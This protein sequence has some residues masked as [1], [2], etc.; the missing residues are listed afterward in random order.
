MWC[1]WLLIVVAVCVV[2][3]EYYAQCSYLGKPVN[4]KTCLCEPG[5]LPPDCSKLNLTRMVGESPEAYRQGV[6]DDNYPTFGGSAYKSDLSQCGGNVKYYWIGQTQ[7]NKAGMSCWAHNSAGSIWESTTDSPLGP[8]KFVSWMGFGTNTAGFAPTDIPWLG[9]FRFGIEAK[10]QPSA[11]SLRNPTYAFVTHAKAK[12]VKK[13]QRFALASFASPNKKQCIGHLGLDPKVNPFWKAKTNVQ[14]STVGY[15][16]LRGTTECARER[17]I[18]SI[19]DSRVL[20]SNV[21]GFTGKNEYVNTELTWYMSVDSVPHMPNSD[22]YPVNPTPIYNSYTLGLLQYQGATGKW[23]EYTGMQPGMYY[24]P[25]F[26]RWNN[27]KKKFVFREKL[28]VMAIRADMFIWE[29]GAPQYFVNQ[30]VGP[31]WY[32]D[33]W[34]WETEQGLHIYTHE[35]GA[36][37]NRKTVLPSCGGSLHLSRA[38]FDS[39]MFGNKWID[40]TGVFDNTIVSL[41]QRTIVKQRPVVFYEDGNPSVLFT[42]NLWKGKF[43][44][45]EWKS[46]QGASRCFAQAVST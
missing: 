15:R 4:K 17:E 25:L 36:C 12:Q 37:R 31:G 3:Q 20:V 23:P 46:K 38:D 34:V 24:R 44:K 30:G 10:L 22:Q 42:G 18:R 5:W 2:A 6:H 13:T 43:A 11:T 19:L 40:R 41:K 28:G 26:I 7:A 21:N 33:P 29:S 9:N 14:V 1:L 27:P 16:I 8:Y 39:L 35:I 45:N 32:E